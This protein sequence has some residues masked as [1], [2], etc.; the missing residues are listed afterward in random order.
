MEYLLNFHTATDT[1]IVTICIGQKVIASSSN[2]DS[3]QH[4]MWLHTSI[5]RLLKENNLQIHQLQGIGVTIGP[6]SYT[7]IRVGLATAKGLCYALK[8]PL[9][10]F[11][12]LEVLALSAA[13]S[14]NDTDSLYCP[15]I[16]ARRM[17][18]YTGIYTHDLM[19]IV[20][21]SAVII[22]EPSFIEAIQ[23]AGPRKIYFFG[24]GSEKFKPIVTE[25]P[26]HFVDQEIT[27][28]ALGRLAW[29]KYQ[30]QEF[31]DLPFSEPL[32]IK[33][34]YSTGTKEG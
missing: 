18:V 3:K 29:V 10:T 4:A 11:N 15:M 27:S 2:S 20:P 13:D 17:E 26:A 7:G 16:D 28:E 21:P 12:S 25:I 5:Q 31:K 30:S 14:L 33:E 22:T 34:F 6:G 9:I 19:E 1:A 24:N 8:I 32:Y 23:N